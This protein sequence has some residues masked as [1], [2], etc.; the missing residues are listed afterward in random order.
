MDWGW[1]VVGKVREAEVRLH[2]SIPV[3]ALLMGGFN[4]VPVFWIGFFGLVLAHEFGHA[5]AVWGWGLRVTHIDVHGLGGL[6][7][8]YGNATPW[9]RARIAWGGVEAQ[10]AVLVVWLLLVGAVGVPTS[11]VG[12]QLHHL[13][14]WTNLWLIG[15]NLLPIPP[16]DGAEAWAVVP[17]MRERRAKQ[18]R[19]QQKK[20]AEER[21]VQESVD[22]ELRRLESLEQEVANRE[23]DIDLDDLLR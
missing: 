6:C 2:W 18:A 11:W 10:L 19:Q 7:R 8:W 23:D 14:V 15:L 16:L 1:L 22:A 12:S 3:A 20:L 4:F 5:R 9:Q 21:R 17:L 13:F